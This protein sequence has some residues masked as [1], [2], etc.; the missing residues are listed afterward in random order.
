[1][2]YDDNIKPSAN[3]KE[4]S[5]FN[6]FECRRNLLDKMNV[7]DQSAFAASEKLST[8]SSVP[9]P[10]AYVS[11]LKKVLYAF[12][13]SKK[14]STPSSV[15]PAADYVSPIKRNI[16]MCRRTILKKRWPE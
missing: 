9:P 13:A 6:I 16:G 4:A 11:P 8:P 5:Y 12:I 15:P 2:N 3:V 10:A 14:P 7:T 1:M